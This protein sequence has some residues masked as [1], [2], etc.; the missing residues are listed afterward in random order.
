MLRVMVTA[1]EPN[2]NG[3]TLGIAI[4][5]MA[6]LGLSAVAATSLLVPSSGRAGGVAKDPAYATAMS[7]AGPATDVAGSTESARADGARGDAVLA[8]A[9]TPDDA[10]TRADGTTADAASLAASTPDARTDSTGGGVEPTPAPITQAPSIDDWNASTFEAGAPL[11]DAERTMPAVK[12]GNTVGAVAGWFQPPKG[13]SVPAGAD[14]GTMLTPPALGTEH[15]DGNCTLRE[16]FEATDRDHDGHPEYVRYRS[17]KVCAVDANQDGH[18]EHAVI[19]A[20]DVQLWDNDSSG[21]FNAI[22]AVQG[23]REILDPNSD[24]AV[25]YLA[26]G[27]WTL[28]AVDA[29]EDGNLDRIGIPFVGQQGVDAN[30]N[31][32][33]EFYP[34]AAVTV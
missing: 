23:A 34:A 5:V 25:E 3:R 28:S 18:P 19:I 11:A 15:R 24:G 9:T 32:N 17:L 1:M 2:R 7:Y 27:R 30:T 14:V 21:K 13:V 31:G 6:V 4:L 29:N 16:S 22:E 10:G 33:A 8:D 20:R 12:D 26:Q